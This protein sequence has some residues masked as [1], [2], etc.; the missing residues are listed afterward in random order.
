[1]QCASCGGTLADT[2]KFCKHC[3]AAVVPAAVS[4]KMPESPVMQPVEPVAGVAPVETG[5][6][7]I[8]AF[9]QAAAMPSIP[10]LPQLTPL[11]PQPETP[12]P[13]APNKNNIIGIVVAACLVVAAAVAV[14]FIFDPFGW[15]DAEDTVPPDGE[16]VILQPVDVQDEDIDTDL[17]AD[18]IE[19]I[20][21][22][23]EPDRS[24]VI[25]E[26]SS[27]TTDEPDENDAVNN[28]SDNESDNESTDAASSGSTSGL[29]GFWETEWVEIDGSDIVMFIAF[30]KQGEFFMVIGWK[31]S[32]T[33]AEVQGEYTING[34]RIFANGINLI[35]AEPVEFTFTH[36]FDGDNLILGWEGQEQYKFN[37]GHPSYPL[38]FDLE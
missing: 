37:R 8:P 31:D 12:P 18:K 3:G 16:D 2:A 15:R 38:F 29:I 17:N 11:P 24:V 6:S 22:D 19:T 23:S 21:P 7:Q 30:G 35:Y 28:E 20:L 34:N 14:Y 5:T 25:E 10:A 4:A 26:E 32:E 13:L 27:D 9:P 33:A 36:E 1:M